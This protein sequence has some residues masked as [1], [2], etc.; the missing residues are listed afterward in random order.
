MGGQPAAE[1]GGLPHAQPLTG[2]QVELTAGEYRAT[3]VTLGG[4]IRSLTHA[5]AALLD[6]Y[7]AEELPQGARGQLLLP[8]PNR[9]RGGR[10]SWLGSPQQ[11]PLDEPGAGNAIH[12]LVRWASWTVLEATATSALLTYQIPA[13][14]GF[15][16]RLACSVTYRLDAV[17]GLTVTIT[18]RGIG[19]PA[20]VAAGM[21]PYLKVGSGVV[22]D[23]LLTVPAATQVLLD[24]HGQPRARAAVAGTD[25]DLRAGRAVGA[26]RWDHCFTDLERAED[27]RATATLRGAQRGVLLWVDRSFEYLMVYSGDTLPDPAQR[28]RA[29]AIEPMTAPPGAL[30][31]RTGVTVVD[32]ATQWSGQFGIAVAPD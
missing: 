16:C 29:V 19:G 18:A 21:H 22:D 1:A 28:R 26:R 10:W 23:A 27:G 25:I 6:G 7:A 8:W 13:R 5:G 17:S 12:G 2:E 31:T 32:E 24:Q 3:V 30:A 14:P 20:P 9:L 11:L 15:P 4:G